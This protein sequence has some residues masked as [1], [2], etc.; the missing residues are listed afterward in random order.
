MA[1]HLLN[2]SHTELQAGSSRGLPLYIR[3]AGCFNKDVNVSTT[4]YSRT[5]ALSGEHDQARG[6]E[7]PHS[8][9][10]PDGL[11]G[12][13]PRLTLWNCSFPYSP[14]EAENYASG[15][16]GNQ[17]DTVAQGINSL[18]QNIERDLQRR[19]NVSVSHWWLA[20][21]KGTGPRSDG[22]FPFTEALSHGSPGRT[23]QHRLQSLLHSE[24]KV[25]FPSLTHLFP[26]NS[27]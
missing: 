11:R 25:M 6:S 24:P 14:E 1:E 3:N 26:Y 9:A 20:S 7:S 2:D 5:L 27:W 12:P 13:S 23:R 4:L 19:K 8:S 15:R 18:H 22:A 10:G 17:R 16:E 21:D